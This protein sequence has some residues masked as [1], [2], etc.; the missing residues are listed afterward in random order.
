M[1]GPPCQ[2][3]SGMGLHRRTRDHCNLFNEVLVLIFLLRP[4]LAIL[5]NVIAL[6]YQIQM[7]AAAMH[8][9]V[10]FG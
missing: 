6:L 7:Q 5:E 4:A 3:F 10:T 1:S 2:P 9:W 8:Y